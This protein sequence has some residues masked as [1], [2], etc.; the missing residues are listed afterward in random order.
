MADAALPS[1]AEIRARFGQAHDAVIPEAREREATAPSGLQEFLDLWKAILEAQSNPHASSSTLAGALHAAKSLGPEH[2]FR[3]RS[4]LLAAAS[5]VLAKL[6]SGE[7][8]DEAVIGAQLES[9]ASFL[10]S[11][12]IFALRLHMQFQREAR[13]EAAARAAAAAEAEAATAAF[14]NAETSDL[15]A[16]QTAR[17]QAEQDGAAAALALHAADEADEAAERLARVRL[18]EDEKAAA[19]LAVAQRMD[20]VL[21]GWLLKAG[22]KNTAYQKRFCV[23][24]RRELAW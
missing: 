3:G 12:F 1:F 8:L 21:T 7:A 18:V 15:E 11:D 10:G 22:E 2:D 16:Q 24:A 19:A 23:L 14:L 5:D 4:E 6:G 13:E 9:L 17:Q 20:I